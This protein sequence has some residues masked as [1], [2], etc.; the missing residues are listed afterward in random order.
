LSVKKDP[1]PG[2]ATEGRQGFL[3]NVVYLYYFLD[4]L[5][6]LHKTIMFDRIFC[7]PS[8][9]LNIWSAVRSFLL[10]HLEHHGC[11]VLAYLDNFCHS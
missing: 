6:L 4:E 8:A 1:Y 3:L 11:T 5:H 7:P 2:V 10:P 9:K